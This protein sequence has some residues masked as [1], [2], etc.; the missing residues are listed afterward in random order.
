MVTNSCLSLKFEQLLDKLNASACSTNSLTS[1]NLP[2]PLVQE[3]FNKVKF[4]TKLD[5]QLY[6][7]THV[8][9]TDGLATKRQRR[10]RPSNDEDDEL[11][12]YLED[13]SGTPVERARI[14]KFGEKARRLFN[15]LRTKGL[16]RE[17]WHDLDDQ[18]MDY[19]QIEMESEFFELRL[20]QGSW[21]LAAWV[22]RVYS[23]WRNNIRLQESK[24]KEKTCKQRHSL[25]SLPLD[26]VDLIKI[27][28][29]DSTNLSSTLSDTSETATDPSA[30][31]PIE[32][33]TSGADAP[34]AVP[35]VPIVL[36]LCFSY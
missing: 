23:S 6:V 24:L 1:K 10:G 5:Y 30:T 13:E 31:D 11:H 20:C 7:K 21:K 25:S 4:W 19:I 26:D 34:A 29:F 9:E 8:G 18:A 28:A 22:P 14:T 3:D 33:S 2:Q 15:S 35:T 12:P 16:D 32:S 17:K 36:F 27:N